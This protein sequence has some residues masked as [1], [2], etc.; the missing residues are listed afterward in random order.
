MAKQRVRSRGKRRSV[1][2]DK[3]RPLKRS[4][5]SVKRSRR[6]AM[7]SRRSAKRSNRRARRSTRRPS[8]R[9]RG[10]MNILP[11][12]GVSASP[13]PASK[14]RKH[15]LTDEVRPK[16]AGWDSVRRRKSIRSPS[17]AGP[18]RRLSMREQMDAGLMVPDM[19]YQMSKVYEEISPIIQSSLNNNVRPLF[20]RAVQD[21][22]STAILLAVVFGIIERYVS[23]NLKS[24]GD[25]LD[26]DMMKP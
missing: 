20:N 1:K 9:M 11:V 14:A 16:S 21:P 12:D 25:V 24:T 3:V 18:A 8:R 10:G 6:S 19:N 4:R 22:T 7:R 2:K 13:S 26:D 23:G 17:P 5:R 15:R